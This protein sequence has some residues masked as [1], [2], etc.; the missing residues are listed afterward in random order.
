MTFAKLNG[1]EL[2]PHDLKKLNRRLDEL[3]DSA[4][5]LATQIQRELSTS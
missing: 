2:P 5:D 4:H 1:D 3:L